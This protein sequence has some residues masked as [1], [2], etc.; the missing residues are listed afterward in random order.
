MCILP[1]Q[2]ICTFS[3]T[4]TSCF[5]QKCLDKF[6]MVEEIMKDST[7]GFLP[8]KLFPF[9]FGFFGFVV[10]RIK[11]RVFCVVGKHPVLE[12][13]QSVFC[14][15]LWCYRSTK[16]LYI[17]GTHLTTELEPPTLFSRWGLV[18][19]FRLP[20]SSCLSFSSTWNYRHMLPYPG[21]S[22]V[23]LFLFFFKYLFL[24]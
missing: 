23:F 21:R 10:L 12:H 24:L 11:P 16:A 19:I 9:N 8:K 20:P 3:S 2:I 18:I 6:L 14:T 7:M 22:W 5:L 15:Y 13:A 1:T 4:F 17:R